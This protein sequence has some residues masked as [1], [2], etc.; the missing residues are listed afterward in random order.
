MTEEEMQKRKEF[1]DKCDALAEFGEGVPNGGW[2][3]PMKYIVKSLKEWAK[4]YRQPIRGT[5]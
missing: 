2:D 4:Q 1:A 3:T 5:I